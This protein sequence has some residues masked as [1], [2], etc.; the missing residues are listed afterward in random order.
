MKERINDNKR[1]DGTKMGV[2]GKIEQVDILKDPQLISIIKYGGTIVVPDN[3]LDIYDF[4]NDMRKVNPSIKVTKSKTIFT[5]ATI[6]SI[7]KKSVM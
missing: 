5:D 6:D 4:F 7:T 3:R 1:L 2:N